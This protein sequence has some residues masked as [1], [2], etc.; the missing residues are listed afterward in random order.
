MKEELKKFNINLDDVEENFN[1]YEQLEEAIKKMREYG[2]RNLEVILNK[3]LLTVKQINSSKMT[4]FGLKVSFEYL[5]KDISFIVRER[6]TPDYE[7]MYF[8]LKEKLE[9]IIK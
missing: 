6:E 1:I 2:Y 5:E 3:N 8:D 4:I 7:K 9:E